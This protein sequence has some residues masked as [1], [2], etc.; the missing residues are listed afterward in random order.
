LQCHIIESQRDL[1]RQEDQL[2]EQIIDKQG[3]IT[4]KVAAIGQEPQS[5]ELQAQ[6]T[7]LKRDLEDLDIKLIS[8][9]REGYVC[10]KLIG[11]LIKAE[12]ASG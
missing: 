8:V 5:L 7:E 4:E 11:D 6:L 9:R 12:Y 2:V 3:G 10:F 1:G